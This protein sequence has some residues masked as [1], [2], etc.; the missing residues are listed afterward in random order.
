MGNPLQ[1]RITSRLIL[2]TKPTFSAEKKICVGK[3]V[4]A[5]FPED[6]SLST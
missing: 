3:I 2:H 1:G 5:L 4:R 6:W